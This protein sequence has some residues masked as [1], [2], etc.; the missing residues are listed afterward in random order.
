MSKAI[1]EALQVIWFELEAVPP[2][3]LVN[4]EA[5]PTRVSLVLTDTT[6]VPH[7]YESGPTIYSNTLRERTLEVWH[8]LTRQIGVS[9]D[10][11]G[12]NLYDTVHSDLLTQFNAMQALLGTRDDTL[13][14][15]HYMTRKF[16]EEP[17]WTFNYYEWS[18]GR[19]NQWYG[20][21]FVA[22]GLPYSL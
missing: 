2:T 6:T 20:S 7:T 18:P 5:Y 4:G 15:W 1:Y 10:Y 13:R 3:V 12:T 11:L 19:P 16:A 14:D 9:S 8:E 17:Y 22:I 21:T